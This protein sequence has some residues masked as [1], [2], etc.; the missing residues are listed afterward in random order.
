M[1]GVAGHFEG[2]V[3]YGRYG[4][5]LWRA[6]RRRAAAMLASRLGPGP[7]R[8]LD[9]GGG[10]LLSL[11]DLAADPRVASWTVVDLV[12]RLEDRPPA[13][14]V[15]RQDAVRFVRDYRGEPFQAV[16]SFGLLMYLRPEDSRALLAALGR[17]C[18]PGA[19]LLSHEPN[20]S[21]GAVLEPSIERPV[22]VVEEARGHWTPAAR[23]RHNH[24]RVWGAAAR[25]P[26]AVWEGAPGDALLAF[27]A[28]LSGGLDTLTLLRKAPGTP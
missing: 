11:P 18:A 28:R 9:L 5:G 17:A 20:A 26:P 13:L 25:L 1:S 6:Y 7:W 15:V 22:D 2:F 4:R 8:V 21:S 3:D 19:M 23:E 12:D 10:S 27:E 16:V 24:P 14:T